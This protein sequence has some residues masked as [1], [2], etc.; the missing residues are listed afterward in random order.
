MDSEKVGNEEL[1][2]KVRGGNMSALGELVSR[3]QDKVLSLAYRF[4][5]RW[6][7]AE[8]IRQETFLRVWRASQNYKP[9][10]RFTT[11]LYS[12]A[13]NLCIDEYRKSIHKTIP[14][15]QVMAD[16]E[17]ESDG[18][19]IER[20]EAAKIVQK[21]IMGLGE[22]QRL[23]V[24]LHRYNGLSHTEISEVTGWSRS[25]VESLIVRAYT[26]LRNK[27]RKSEDFTK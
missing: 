12:I 19:S 13:I 3:H 20:E 4:F 2:A 18:D 15:E 1:M 17:A 25:A 10:A 24:I 8:D 16:L 23:A 5:G 22:R 9:K 6:D 7:I 14:L 27:L 11:W 21:A 26:N